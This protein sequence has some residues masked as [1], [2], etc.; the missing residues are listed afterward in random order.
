MNPEIKTKWIAALRS[1]SY[2]QTT[3]VLRDSRGYCC[4]GVLCDVVDPDKWVKASEVGDDFTQADINDERNQQ[5]LPVRVMKATCL[6][7]NEQLA[8]SQMNDTGSSFTAI[9][10]HIEATF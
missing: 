3:G 6:H 9:A 7:R 10:D 1:G 5:L 4:L 2:K 8:L